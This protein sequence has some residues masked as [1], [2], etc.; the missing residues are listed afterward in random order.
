MQSGATVWVFNTNDLEWK[1]LDYIP[2]QHMASLKKN[3][4]GCQAV[5]YQRKVMD[6]G[7]G[8]RDKERVALEQDINDLLF[9]AKNIL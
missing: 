2:Y 8:L 9:K 4:R 7:S 3:D 6:D 1:F 5:F